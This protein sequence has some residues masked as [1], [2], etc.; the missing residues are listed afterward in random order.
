MQRKRLKENERLT[1]VTDAEAR[2]VVALLAFSQG[3]FKLQAN[4]WIC[5]GSSEAEDSGADLWEVGA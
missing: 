4:P 1:V 5:I 3:E 2:V